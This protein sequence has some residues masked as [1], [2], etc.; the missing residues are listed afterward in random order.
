MQ[1]ELEEITPPP[2]EKHTKRT[3]AIIAV[4]TLIV[5]TMVGVFG[6]YYM[7]AQQKQANIE[8]AIAREKAEKAAKEKRLKQ[9][10]IS[11]VQ[12][13]I[14]NEINATSNVTDKLL[15]SS[16]DALQKEASSAIAVGKD[17]AAN[18]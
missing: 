1:P 11:G 7:A 17:N 14:E 2:P 10:T 4:I 15:F 3:I 13:T 18:F 16:N 12:A 9:G 6:Y 5:L 8:A